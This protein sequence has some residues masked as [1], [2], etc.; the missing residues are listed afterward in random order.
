VVDG[1]SGSG[2]SVI[3]WSDRDTTLL[4]GDIGEGASFGF[5]DGCA[6]GD[7][8]AVGVENGV[9]NDEDDAVLVPF[10]VEVVVGVVEVGLPV[11]GLAEVMRNRSE[12]G[13]P[14]LSL[15]KG[16]LDEPEA[17]RECPLVRPSALRG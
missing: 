13:V 7:L 17:C 12:L 9:E 10:V 3:N 16:L 15:W 6:E 14:R 8:A 5:S 2:R 11:V 1:G 4:A